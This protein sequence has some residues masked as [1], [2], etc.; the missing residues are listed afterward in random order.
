MLAA[1]ASAAAAAGACVRTV[2]N[3]TLTNM[4][5]A[6]D[7]AGGSLVGLDGSSLV[8]HTA[9]DDADAFARMFLIQ[10]PSAAS[11]L[12]H[13]DLNGDGSKDFAVKGPRGVMW[14]AVAGGVPQ[15]FVFAY[16]CPNITVAY[17]IGD[18]NGDGVADAVVLTNSSLGAALGVGGGAFTPLAPEVAVAGMLGMI[19]CN[20]F[21]DTRVEAATWDAG[22]VYV[23]GAGPDA[24]AP[25]VLP[26]GAVVAMGCADADGDGYKD[27]LISARSAVYVG[28]KV[29]AGA[30]FFNLVMVGAKT[31]G[32]VEGGE[33]GAGSSTHAH[34]I[35][36]LDLDLD[37]A[38][39]LLV[40]D[41]GVVRWYPGRGGGTFMGENV[42]A[43][44]GLRRSVAVYG[45]TPS[46]ATFLAYSLH[47]ASAVVTQH[48]GV[49]SAGSGRYSD[50]G[51]AWSR[52]CPAGRF[53]SKAGSVGPACEG[54]CR[55]GFNC[56]PGSTSAT[57]A[58]C[59]AG[60]FCP[61]NVSSAPC[62]GG[63]FSGP[64]GASVGDC[65][66]CPLPANCAGSGSCR[67]G[68]GGVQCGVCSAGFYTGVA[69]C[70]SCH[71]DSWLPL[72]FA[73]TGLGLLL[74]LAVSG[75]GSLRFFC[76]LR[77]LGLHVQLVGVIFHVTTAWNSDARL[78]VL[79]MQGFTGDASIPFPECAVGPGLVT[80]LWATWLNAAVIATICGGVLAFL[81]LCPPRAWAGPCLV[82]RRIM[83]MHVTVLYLLLQH[84][85]LMTT[86]LAA[87]P[88]ID[89]PFGSRVA[90]DVTILCG[91]D[92]ALGRIVI[93]AAA[94]SIAVLLTFGAPFMLF[95]G[96]QDQLK[97]AAAAAGP[98]ATPP[99]P[100]PSQ[101]GLMPTILY[102]YEAGRPDFGA[103]LMFRGIVVALAVVLR[104]G[105]VLETMLLVL[106]VAYA[107]HSAREGRWRPVS[108]VLGG[109]ALRNVNGWL[110]RLD[111][112]ALVAL[113]VLGTATA[114]EASPGDSL[115]LWVAAVTVAAASVTVF[116]V[117]IG[118]MA[119]PAG[120]GGTDERPRIAEV[121]AELRG[122]AERGDGAAAVL[123]LVA[124]EA[125]CERRL[126]QLRRAHECV[127]GGD[128]GGSSPAEFVE[129]AA[130]LRNLR[131]GG[132]HDRLSAS[133][134]AVE[135]MEGR[136][137]EFA[138]AAVAQ[139]ADALDSGQMVNVGDNGV[140]LAVAVQQVDV[141]V[142]MGR[143]YR[144]ALHRVFDI[145]LEEFDCDVAMTVA[146][147]LERVRAELAPL[148]PLD[149]EGEDAGV[150]KRLAVYEAALR[151]G[152]LRA[153]VVLGSARREL[154]IRAAISL[155]PTAA[156]PRRAA[157]VE[158]RTFI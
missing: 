122:C 34:S 75:R 53:A 101:A 86:M 11:E 145:A 99:L 116:F 104:T 108:L 2:H 92:G 40:S 106:F 31:P 14:S 72:A 103:M 132:R 55:P 60:S 144:T 124:L 131:D 58:A 16:D 52:L 25:L 59:S 21:G 5:F 76:V 37:G 128:G 150:A 74:G 81:W 110:A 117:V 38:T 105:A 51:A 70:K 100:P 109:R 50:G 79:Y 91:S 149:A 71:D 36:L 94:V 89:T 121:R 111:G 127:G 134:S 49:V 10:T 35:K 130:V 65:L 42:L 140:A 29:P 39:D 27:F 87:V 151:R 152:T 4:V 12:K 23:W 133:W 107:A 64:G 13:V 1:R 17:G 125:S 28:F 137:F 83:A 56:A 8:W 139:I 113:A 143:L 33:Q 45:S 7:F 97:A 153:H 61:G 68:S 63:T 158:A 77:V 26:V 146:A 47:N 126:A 88:C 147:E 90:V 24:G 18:R 84:I 78:W 95:R 114:W 154:G 80:R 141:A 112:A 82:K 9:S 66:A 44:D 43:I 136:Q 32:L 119:L 54:P 3:G 41:E 73:Y 129:V 123:L 46:G 118:L 67:A 155:L 102:P 156:E 69:G 115:R 142:E 120:G 135:E 62:P 20:I 6:A 138:L 22:A 93:V 96:G 57:A 48:C 148:A 85:P 98:A 157:A 15:R 19:T 30:D